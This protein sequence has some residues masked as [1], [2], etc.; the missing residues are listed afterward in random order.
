MVVVVGKDKVRAALVSTPWD[1]LNCPS[2]LVE[3]WVFVVTPVEKLL[4]V[5]VRF[6]PESRVTSGPLT[7]MTLDPMAV[8]GAA[9][10][11]FAEKHNAKVMT[12]KRKIDIEQTSFN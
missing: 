4:S 11:P 10:V 7:V 1:E 6:E 5:T 3:T 8:V 2:E 12:L 9:H